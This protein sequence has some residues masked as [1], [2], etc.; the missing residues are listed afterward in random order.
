MADPTLIDRL[1]D[2]L[3]AEGLMRRPDQVGPGARP[4]LPPVWRM[5]DEGAIGPG[6]MADQGKPDAQRDDG[7]VV[8]LMFAP[9]IPSPVGGEDMRTDGVDIVM[10]GRAVAPIADL[11]RA[12]RDRLLGDDPGGRTDWVMGGLYVIQ[13]RQWRPFQ[14]I[15]S[16][17]G[18]YTFSVGYIFEL[19]A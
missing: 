1:R 12:V 17:A 5:P 8:S 19:Q 16:G 11:E 15:S 10:R 14:P 7:L 6:D 18:V 13:S 2:F 9:G 3:V 4:W